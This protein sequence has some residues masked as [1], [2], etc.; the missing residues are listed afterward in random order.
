MWEPN[1]NPPFCIG[2]ACLQGKGIKRQSAFA[3]SG[4]APGLRQAPFL[5]SALHH[6]LCSLCET[7]RGAAGIC[8]PR[9]S[10]GGVGVCIIPPPDLQPAA[11]LCCQ[12]NFTPVSGTFIL[13]R[14]NCK[15]TCRHTLPPRPSSAVTPQRETRSLFRISAWFSLSSAWIRAGI[16]PAFKHCLTC[17]SLL[18]VVGK[19]KRSIQLR[20][21]A[22]KQQIPK[23]GAFVGL[24]LKAG[25]WKHRLI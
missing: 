11:L 18:L 17:C 12:G 7:F 19:L 2:A 9:R 20:N 16:L 14:W 13:H 8:A 1:E 4:S 6:A 15:V 5:R 23:K 25:P 10:S 3:S 21:V 24:T 22:S